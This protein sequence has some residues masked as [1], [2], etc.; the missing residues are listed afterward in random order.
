MDLAHEAVLT[1]DDLLYR[2]RQS[3]YVGR[4]LRGRV[5]RTLVRGR[6]VFQEGRIV[7]EPGGRLVRP[8]VAGALAR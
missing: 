3:P 1:A 7:G 8:A 5:V 6:T 2:H 4:R